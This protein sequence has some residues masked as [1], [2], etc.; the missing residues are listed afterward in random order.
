MTNCFNIDLKTT[1]GGQKKGSRSGQRFTQ[2]PRNVRPDNALIPAGFRGEEKSIPLPLGEV[3]APRGAELLN[4]F[5]WDAG[6]LEMGTGM[7]PAGG[8]RD[9]LALQ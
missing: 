5:E 6:R 3:Y 1:R 4:R 7:G 8:G 9:D 2:L